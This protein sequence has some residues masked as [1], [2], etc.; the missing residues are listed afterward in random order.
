MTFTQLILRCYQSYFPRYM[1]NFLQKKPYF[2][3]NFEIILSQSKKYGKLL[4]NNLFDYMIYDFCLAKITY[5]YL[6]LQLLTITITSH[7]AKTITFPLQCL[8]T[9]P[10]HDDLLYDFCLATMI[11]AYP[12]TTNISKCPLSTMILQDYWLPIVL[13]SLTITSHML[14]PSI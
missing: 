14:K 1:P 3:Q 6:Q 7:Y 4:L 8:V 10:S 13:H 12:S 9:T 5:N 2:R 11:T